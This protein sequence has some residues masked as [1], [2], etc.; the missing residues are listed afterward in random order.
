MLDSLGDRMKGYEEACESRLLPGLPIVA[1][2]DG[3]AFHT[4]TNNLQRPY[5][6]SF[7]KMMVETTI[8][9]MEESSAL[10][11]YT[12]SDEISLLF[13]PKTDGEQVFFNGR[14][15][16]LVS[17]LASIATLCFYKKQCMYNINV[18][19]AAHFDCR[20]FNTP[21]RME[22]YN[23]FLW[24]EK[25]A[26]KNSI[27]MAAQSYYSHNELQGKNSSD[28]QEMLFQK[29]VNWNDYPACFKRGTYIQRVKELKKFTSSE[30][31][32]LPAGHEARKNPDLEFYRSCIK[33]VE[34]PPL[35]KV[36][37]KIEFIFGEAQ[38]Y[39]IKD[40]NE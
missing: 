30:I 17:V 11:G 29:G 15:D 21:T 28:K 19:R 40:T 6:N 24:R 20:V 4:F 25:D 39:E 31:E 10:L 5:D 16:K 1:R 22:A 38:P 14:R 26:T 27:S 37:N 36:E 32:G 2:I 34:T 7:N 3:R 23:Y 13:Y 35:S 33:V 18:A 12:Q 8:C 9:L